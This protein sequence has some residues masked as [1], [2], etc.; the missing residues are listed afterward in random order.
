MLCHHYVRLFIERETWLPCPITNCLQLFVACVVCE[1]M[2]IKFL[3]KN[4][5]RETENMDQLNYRQEDTHTHTHTHT[6]TQTSLHM[7]Q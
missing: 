2:H 5:K 1:N 6:H 7:S 4:K 3:K